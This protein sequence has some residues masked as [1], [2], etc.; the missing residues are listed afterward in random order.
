MS[1]IQK[2][3]KRIILLAVLLIAVSGYAEAQR[4]VMGNKPYR[5]FNTRPGYITVNEFGSGFGLGGT[6]TDYSKYFF[7]F[8]SIHAYQVDQYLALGAGTGLSFYEDGLLIPL[9]LDIR[10]RYY[11]NTMTFYAFGDGGFLLNPSDFNSGT[12]MFI[13]AGPGVRFAASP[14]LAFNISPGLMIQMGPGS[15][16]SF[17]NFRIGATFKPR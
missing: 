4:R 1:L 10:F 3:M 9:F 16:A 13:N 12:R 6:T 14:N 15:R 11:V 5:N 8:T 17:I 2:V 7:G